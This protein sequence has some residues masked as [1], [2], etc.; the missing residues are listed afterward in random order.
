MR[1]LAAL[2]VLV[3]LLGGGIALLVRDDGGQPNARLSVA[4][5]LGGDADARYARAIAPRIFNFPADHGPHPEFRTEWWYYTGNVE[6]V[7]GRHFG[8]Q[9]TFFRAALAPDPGPVTPSR[10]SAWAARHIYMAHFAVTDSVGLRFHPHSR[11]AR[12]AAGLAGADA[13]PFRVWVEDWAVEGH[14]PMRL[15]AAD[16]DVAIDLALDSPRPPVLQGEHGLS[17]KGPE[18]GNASYYYSLTRMPT[19]GVVRVGNQRFEVRGLSWM[20]REWSTSALG[21][22]RGWDWFALQLDDGRDVMYYR[23]RH[24]DGSTTRFSAGSLVTADG[25]A[26]LL[27]VEDVTLE[28]LDSWTS[29]R[30]DVRYP[31][32]W[33]MTIPA[34]RLSVEIAP[35]VADQEHIEPFPYWEGAV[36]VRPFTGRRPH[37]T[38]GPPESDPPISGVGYVELVGYGTSIAE[39][40]P[41]TP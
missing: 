7:E 6:T 8:Y 32:R 26:R 34:E 20:D 3:G 39:R 40:M 38:A 28:V 33:R 35:R 12:G 30:G 23:L 13:N 1:G 16:G 15:R 22:A 5:A 19:S 2:L 9:L 25:R 18:P 21:D 4:E 11:L 27:G 36:I 37:S 31:A 24:A 17:R 14:V 29:P 41:A 10:S